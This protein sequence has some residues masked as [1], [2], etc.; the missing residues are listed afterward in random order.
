LS[1]INVFVLSILMLIVLTSFNFL[2]LIILVILLTYKDISIIKPLLIAL[3]FLLVISFSLDNIPPPKSDQIQTL[4]IYDNFEK[5]ED[6]YSFYAKDN[7]KHYKVSVEGQIPN[8]ILND[9]YGSVITFNPHEIE[10]ITSFYN[11]PNSFDYATYMSSKKI[12]YEISTTDLELIKHKKSLVYRIKNFRHKKVIDNSTKY[13]EVYPYINALVFGEKD[14]DQELYDA[15]ANI[16][17]IHMLT[18]SGAHLVLILSV[19]RFILVLLNVLQKK[20]GYFI[21]VFIF[22]YGILAGS[23]IPILRAGFVEIGMLVT[24]GKYD[25]R[26]MNKF[27]FVLLFILNP[28]VITSLSY[29]LTFAIAFFLTHFNF[30]DHI[31]STSWFVNNIKTTFFITLAT[32][33]LIVNINYEINPLLLFFNL[34]YFPIISYVL[35]PLSFILTF[36]PDSFFLVSLFNIVISIIEPLAII[37]SKFTIVIGELSGLFFISYYYLLYYFVI[38]GNYY[39][40]KF[41]VLLLFIASLSFNIVGSVNFIDIGQ[42]DSTFI[43]LPFNHGN[44]LIDTGPNDS[45]DELEAFLK[46][47]G[48]KKLDAIFITHPHEDHMGS[49]KKIMN[50]FEFETIYFADNLP[51]DIEHSKVEMLDNESIVAFGQY[52]FNFYFLKNDENVNNLSTAITVTLGGKDFLFTG[53]MESNG[54]KFLLRNNYDIDCDIYQVGHHGSHT[55]SSPDFLKEITPS[56]SII[57]SG[58]F[59]RFGHPHQDTIYNLEKMSSNIHITMADGIKTYYFIGDFL[60]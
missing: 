30:E 10:P 19:V 12:H 37:G 50:D 14:F 52:H 42:G 46:Y 4:V 59:N 39:Y 47:K 35:L 44:I 51:I 53:D 24:K 5:K 29:Q 20:H 48:V 16:G 56:E 31:T 2:S 49:I 43:E 26:V 45:Y 33:P 58:K 1:L 36:L 28:L 60:W 55:S 21:M 15:Y 6:K 11:N 54:E 22:V 8:E 9:P 38:L 25:K 27:I 3:I 13:P 23:Q 32:F 18:I 41:I 17:I 7:N 57:S 34:I 40:L